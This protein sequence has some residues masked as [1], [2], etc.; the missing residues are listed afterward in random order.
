MSHTLKWNETKFLNKGLFQREHTAA[1]YIMGGVITGC[2]LNENDVAFFAVFMSWR[3][4]NPFIHKWIYNLT[5]WLG[6]RGPIG[7]THPQTQLFV[8]VFR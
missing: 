4:V 6:N 7:L 1:N 2:L 5:T 3:A 8:L